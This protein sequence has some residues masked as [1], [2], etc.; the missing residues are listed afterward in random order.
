MGCS[1]GAFAQTNATFSLHSSETN[2]LSGSEVQIQ[3]QADINEVLA[4][5]QFE[6][7][8]GDDGRATVVNRSVAT[9]LTYVSTNPADPFATGLPTALHAAEAF[10]DVLVGLWKAFDPGNSADGIQPGVRVLETLTLRL[11]GMGQLNIGIRYPDAAETQTN[12][13]GALFTTVSIQTSELTFN[14]ALN[15]DT[16]LDGDVDLEEFSSVQACFTGSGGT[17]SPPCLDWDLDGDTDIDGDDYKLLAAC[18]SGPGVAASN[19]CTGQF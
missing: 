7:Y 6:V 13:D 14:M 9:D 17:P 5:T 2:V 18:M 19:E 12:L 10:V 3:V 1:S 8:A 11:S 16:D 15:A 4:A